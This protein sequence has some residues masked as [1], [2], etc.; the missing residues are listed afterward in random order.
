MAGGAKRHGRNDKK[1]Q[2]YQALDT[3][4]KNR[5]KKLKQIIKGFKYPQHF[6]V[7]ET[8]ESAYISKL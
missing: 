4:Q 8:K 5:V 6:K 7:V 3:E 1:C 2:Q